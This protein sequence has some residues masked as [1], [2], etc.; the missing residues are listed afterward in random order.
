MGAGVA[1]CV[2][3]IVE[4]LNAKK[5]LFLIEEPETELHPA[6]LR[7]LLDL[8]IDSA[9]SNGNQFII[10][11]HSNIVVRHLGS[12][13]MTVINEVQRVPD[14]NPPKSTVRLVGADARSRIDLLASLGYQFSDFELYSGWLI[15]EESSAEAI[16]REFL[17]KWF[18]PKLV[19]RLCTIAAGGAQDVEPR[20]VEFAR[21]FTFIHKEPAYKNR[22]WV[23]CDGDEAG[24]NTVTKL[25]ERFKEWPPETFRTFGE[26]SFESYYPRHFSTDVTRTLAIT[27]KKAKWNEKK[28]LVE[29]VKAWLRANEEDGR[30][31]L[32]ESA[33][34]VIKILQNIEAL[35]GQS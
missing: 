16:I 2:G 14:S 25:K 13:P 5:R 24:L 30:K 33:A 1:N 12:L 23:V 26:K 29:F 35:I 18:A 22:A 17:L 15:L 32:Q 9:R 11:T 31:Q 21:I 34:P 20:F 10:S 3:L 28:S 4:L 19:G 27:D 6:A 8:I 7:A